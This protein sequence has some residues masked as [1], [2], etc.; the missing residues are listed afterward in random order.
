[1]IDDDD[2]PIRNVEEFQNPAF[3]AGDDDGAHTSEVKNGSIKIVKD[4]FSPLILPILHSK[5]SIMIR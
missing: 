4:F 3:L 2:Q 1:M 5:A